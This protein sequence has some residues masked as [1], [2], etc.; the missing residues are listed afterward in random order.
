L[1]Q[2]HGGGAG[3]ITQ[4]GDPPY[5]VDN[6]RVRVH[7]KKDPILALSNLRAP[8]KIANVFA[9][10]SFVDELAADA[11]LDPVAFRLGKLTD[12]RAVEVIPRVARAINWQPRPSPNPVRQG[13]MLAGRGIA[14]M[15][16]K[17]AENYVAIAMD[18]AVDITTGRISVRRAVCAHDCGL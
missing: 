9:V 14:Y 10:E 15:R 4:N 1:P 3:A 7:W 16:Y 13:R 12:P 17:Q 6:L 5:A 2:E 11:G 18:V 8:G